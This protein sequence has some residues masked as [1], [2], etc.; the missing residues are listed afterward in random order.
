[1]ATGEHIELRLVA[2]TPGVEVSG[3]DLREPFGKAQMAALRR[4]WLEHLTLFFENRI[5]WTSST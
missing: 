1:M 3:V 4:A 5:S 2:E